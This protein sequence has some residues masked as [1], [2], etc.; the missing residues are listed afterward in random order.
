MINKKTPQLELV[1]STPDRKIQ[2]SATFHLAVDAGIVNHDEINYLYL[3][4]TDGIN[5]AIELEQLEEI[6]AKLR[7]YRGGH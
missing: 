1:S 4:S 5:H 2:E 3:T 6:I 7:N